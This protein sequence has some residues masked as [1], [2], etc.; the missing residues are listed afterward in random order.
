M[1]SAEP[2]FILTDAPLEGLPPWVAPPDCGAVAVFWGRVRDHNEGRAVRGLEYST[3]PELAL[4]EGGRILA[5]ARQ[6]FA[7]RACRA[8]HRTGVLDLGEAAVLVEA[9]AAHRGPAF[10]AC[11][12]IID[13]IKAR[14]PLWK[15]EAYVTGETAWVMCHDEPTTTGN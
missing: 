5:E 14:V 11:S 13:Q 9:A 10:E 4:K 1:T 15:K 3:Y 6:R 12:W 7:I 8:V 2:G